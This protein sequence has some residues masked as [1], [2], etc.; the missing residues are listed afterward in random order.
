MVITLGTYFYRW[1]FLLAAA[2]YRGLCRNL[3][4]GI[5]E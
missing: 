1:R 3:V 4:V 2:S 5:R